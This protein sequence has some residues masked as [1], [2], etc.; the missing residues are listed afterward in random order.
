M[1]PLLQE[2]KCLLCVKPKFLA[3]S[4]GSR[5]PQALGSPFLQVRGS[6]QTQQQAVQEFGL[7]RVSHLYLDPKQLQILL[8]SGADSIETD[9][10]KDK[11]WLNLLCLNSI[12]WTSA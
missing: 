10:E 3:A 2:V 9:F 12:Y 1:L 6:G 7:P 11:V 4:E 5:F 8:E